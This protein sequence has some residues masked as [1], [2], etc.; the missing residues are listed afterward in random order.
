MIYDYAGAIHF[1]SDYS[2][3]GT[4]SMEEILAEAKKAG[5]DFCVLTDHHTLQ[6]KKD[7]WEGWKDGVLSIV[8]QEI[9]PRWNHYL[10]L[11]LEEEIC[12]RK[13]HDRP[14]E[15]VEQVARMGGV[16]FAAHPDHPGAP[17]WNMRSYR[18]T[19]FPGN[20]GGV[21]LWDLQTDWQ[22]A[23]TGY[24]RSLFAYWFP[25]LYLEGP[26]PE[27]LA[28]WDEWNRN[29]P[30]GRILPGIGE[31]DNHARRAPAILGSAKIGRWFSIFPFRYAFR[32]IRTHVLL[33]EP[34]TKKDAGEDIRRVLAGLKE[35]RSYIALERWKS[36]KGF[37]MR[38][39]R[40]RERGP[41]AGVMEPWNKGELHGEQ[42]SGWRGPAAAVPF[43]EDLELEARLP[44][45]GWG[46]W[47]RDG[48]K[49]RE[50]WGQEDRCPVDRPGAYRLEV[51]LRKHLRWRPWIFTNPILVKP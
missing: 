35:G 13:N 46:R 6:A 9:S 42:A 39:R 5:L 41:L 21:G 50:F 49:V 51:Y 36:A 47:L 32:T 38:I 33:P 3:D 16:G 48:E 37:Q 24:L 22:A 31:I 1:H 2:Y 44:A 10:A 28:R 8:G 18:W 19:E 15:Y 20:G 43:A 17:L 11:G 23:L 30:D 29:P 12:V 25:T 34:L 7:G 27:T 26:R 14:Q 45:S 4:V 40:K